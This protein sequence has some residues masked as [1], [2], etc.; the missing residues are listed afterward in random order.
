M[1]SSTGWVTD[2]DVISTYCGDPPRVRYICSATATVCPDDFE[3]EGLPHPTRSPRHRERRRKFIA[4][5]AQVG[6]H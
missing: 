1:K 2:L 5:H 4:S 6:V 3:G